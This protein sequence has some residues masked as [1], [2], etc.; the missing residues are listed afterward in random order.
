MLYLVLRPTSN[1]RSVSLSPSRP[2]APSRPARPPLQARSRPAVKWRTPRRRLTLAG[3][4][5]LG[6]GLGLVLQL[7]QYGRGHPSYSWASCY[8]WFLFYFAK[9]T[10]AVSCTLMRFMLL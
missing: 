6:L 5:I 9:M 4:A 10:L 3:L 2:T 7:G 8:F 1:T